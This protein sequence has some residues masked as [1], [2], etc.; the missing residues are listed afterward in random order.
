MQ[1]DELQAPTITGVPHRAVDLI[2]IHCSATPSGKSLQQG[3][4]GSIGYLNCAQVINAWHAAR[5]FK[6]AAAARAAFNPT[7]T[8]IGYHFVVDL[9]GQVFTGRHLDEIPAQAAGFNAHAIGICMVGGTETEGRY[10]PAQWTSLATVVSWLLAEY[11]LPAAAPRRVDDV[12]ADMGYRVTG[13]VCGHRDLSP[14]LNHN[15]RTERNEWVK[16][17]PGFDVSAWLA[18]RLQPLPQHMYLEQTR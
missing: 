11:H 14:D 10:T 6:R 9:D 2:V 18:N 15:G 16:T 5:G 1:T 3:A 17:C 7:L 4:R 13:G 12:T 8:A